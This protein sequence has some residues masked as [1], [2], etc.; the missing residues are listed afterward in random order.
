MKLTLLDYQANKTTFD[1]GDIDQ[2]EKIKIVVITGDEI[3]HVI[4]KDGS[5]D[6]F[7]SCDCRITDYH[8][9]AYKIYDS[10]KENNLL[11][12]DGWLERKDSYDYLYDH[13]EDF[14]DEDRDEFGYEEFDWDDDDLDDE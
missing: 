7:D 11:F 4:Y 6:N 5:E 14:D 10:K 3:A 8:D 13:D 1:I 9:G 2:I 12:D